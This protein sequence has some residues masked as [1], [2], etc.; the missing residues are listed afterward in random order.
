[1]TS[2]IFDVLNTSLLCQRTIALL[3]TTFV[4]Y[5]ISG[6]FSSPYFHIFKYFSLTSYCSHD[7]RPAPLTIRSHLPDSQLP[8]FSQL[9]CV[10]VSPDGSISS[11]YPSDY[12]P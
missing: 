5:H 4:V 9:L 12:S 1:M 2:L 11:L 3:F 6:L 10:P 8:A 7:V